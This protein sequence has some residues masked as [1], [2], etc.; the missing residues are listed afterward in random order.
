MPHEVATSEMFTVNQDGVYLILTPKNEAFDRPSARTQMEIASEITKEVLAHDGVQ[1]VILDLSSHLSQGG[2]VK[3][4]F[5]VFRKTLRVEC[6]VVV[7]RL[8]IGAYTSDFPSFLNASTSIEEA[9]Q[10]LH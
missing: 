1:Y 3:D 5:T 10:L 7:P 9:M 8:K 2:P 6:A 4:M